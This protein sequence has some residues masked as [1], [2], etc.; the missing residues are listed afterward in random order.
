MKHTRWI[1]LGIVVALGGAVRAQ[2]PAVYGR[3]D[4]DFAARLLDAGYKDLF[5]S[6][7]TKM[8]KDLSGGAN[9]A[10]NIKLRIISRLNAANDE[11]DPVKKRDEL[12]G[13]LNDI[14]D[15]VTSF[16]RSD[17]ALWGREV[18]PDVYRMI[19]DAY[20]AL[21]KKE[22]ETSHKE[23]LRLKAQ[24]LFSDAKKKLKTRVE[25]L[26][27]QRADPTITQQQSD[28]LTEQILAARYSISKLEYFNSKLYGPDEA[29]RENHLKLAISEFEDFFLEFDKYYQH[30]E[31]AVYVGLCYRDLGK[32]EDALSSFD[33]AIS[34]RGNWG[35]LDPKT[36]QYPVE[37]ES[38]EIVANLVGNAVLQKIKLFG[39]QKDLAHAT[40]T[41]DDFFKTI[42][43]AD[44]SRDALAIRAAL[45]KVQFDSGE[46]D[47]AMRSAGEIQKL[48]PNGPYG[49][50]ARQMIGGAADLPAAALPADALLRV[51][52][53]MAS[54]KNYDRAL[55][56]LARA[57]GAAVGT[58]QEESIGSNALETAGVIFHQLERYQE[59][60]VAF[61][62]VWELY[63][64]SDRAPICLGKSIDTYNKLYQVEKK[65]FYK[66]RAE[67]RQ[68][69]LAQ[70][71]PNNSRA[72]EAKFAEGKR[73]EEQKDWL[74]AAT[75]YTSFVK[76]APGYEK[77][78]F[79]AGRCYFRYAREQ[80]PL[81][82]LDDAKTYFK[83]A[84]DI[85][86]QCHERCDEVLAT[87]LD[88]QVVQQLSTLTFD[89]R[90]I[91]AQV[92]L[93][94]SINRP[95]DVFGL[96]AD[97]DS[98]LPTDAQRIAVAWQ[99]RIQ[100]LTMQNK[101]DDAGGQLDNLRQRD[102]NSPA[103]AVAAGVLARALDQAGV[104]AFE[105][106]PKSKAG[107]DYWHRAGNY[108]W[109]SVS[110]DLKKPAGPE[111]DDANLERV[112]QRL[113]VF[114]LQFNG[115]GQSSTFVGGD[116]K[117]AAKP[118][119]FEKVITIL[120]L[121]AKN[122]SAG[123]AINDDRTIV[124][125]RA[126][127]FLAHWA[128]ADETLGALFAAAKFIDPTSQRFIPSV[129]AARKKLI[130]AYLDWAVAKQFAGVQAKDAARTKDAYDALG[131]VLTNTSNES[132]LWWSAKYYQLRGLF[133]GGDYDN[134]AFGLRD[135]ERN[136]DIATW[137]KFG[138]KDKLSKLKVELQ[139]R[140]KYDAS[141]SAPPEEK[142]K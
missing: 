6:F 79:Y 32:P 122:S 76:D 97:I 125:A 4:A 117:P 136:S 71:Y 60:S 78:L 48:D 142:K 45:M 47:A 11:A 34:L 127:G 14:N 91:R 2:S 105:K 70:S 36:G 46:T 116:E 96:L 8:P 9:E 109:L 75:F 16:P 42:P 93:E 57:R 118:E 90:F 72:M 31:G 13:V 37:P 25:E 30:Y 86:K 49:Q 19:S 12:L 80:V 121:L 5:E 115:V 108:Y 124:L 66:K 1:T 59:A 119:F 81:K 21:I 139:K 24:E 69:S 65:S 106:D 110:E 94:D 114:A 141:P 126:H 123:A 101:L 62:A 112:A 18:Q 17:E 63:P 41:Y 20:A 39:D 27:Q 98:K 140:N 56:F 50:L 64:K 84:D 135:L 128:E 67:D 53:E 28:F 83:K 87:S 89:A 137:E 130:Y 73:Y 33:D 111:R 35:D 51:A 100:S 7:A 95:Q 113:N 92:A 22:T 102:P 138:L 133:D 40:E 99:L 85:E 43:K 129:L 26:T 52:G 134:A 103:V 104:D 38:Q 23:E 132:Q 82:K 44:Q 15:L 131:R 61:D 107:D 77:G 58:S 3:D 120:E 10:P 54:A 74:K 55:E 88:T 68:N 29:D